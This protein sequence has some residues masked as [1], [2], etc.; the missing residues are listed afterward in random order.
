MTEQ[1]LQ[2]QLLSLVSR[3]GDI[4]VFVAMFFESSIVPIPSE[5][6][7][8]GA[9]AIGIPLSSIIIFGGIGSVLGG[10][11]GY[12]IGRHAAYPLILKFGK[13]ICIRA[14]HIEKAEAFA[15]KYG[16]WGV[17]GGRLMPVVPFKVFSIAS[18]LVRTPPV[19]FVVFTLIGVLPRIFLLACFGSVIVKYHRVVLAGLVLAAV[20]VGIAVY[21]KKRR[22]E[23]KTTSS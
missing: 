16:A 1:V 4:G 2:D 23:A 18:G 12:L 10:T 11:V 17:L 22:R 8:I 3:W 9:G 14:H 20:A 21:L 19:V 13:Y 5:L 7:I 15:R 6:I